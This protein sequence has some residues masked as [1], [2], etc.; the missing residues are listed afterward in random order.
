MRK[1]LLVSKLIAFAFVTGLLSIPLRAQE[2]NVLYEETFD[3]PS[4]YPDSTIKALPNGWVA[5]GETP[6][7]VQSYKIYDKMA[8]TGEF[9]IVSGYPQMS[10]R[11]DVAFSPLFEMKA[12]TDYRIRVK[13]M[14]PGLSPRTSE[15]KITVGTGQDYDS[16][17][18]YMYNDR[19]KAIDKWTLAEVIYTPSQDGQYCVGLWNCST[20][21]SAGDVYYDTFSIEEI[22]PEPE[23]VWEA[24]LPYEESFDDTTHYTADAVLPNG[25]VS[26][27]DNAFQP[28]KGDDYGYVPNSGENLL[29]ANPSY[30]AG[31]NDVTF[32]P[33]LEMEAGVTYQVSFYL[34]LI[35]LTRTPSFKFTVG[36]GQDIGAQTTILKAYENTTTSG[37][38]KVEINFTPT[39]TAQYCFAFWACSALSMDGFMLIDDFVIESDEIAE[40]GWA[41]S[42][43]YLETFDDRTHYDGV[44]YLPV[45]WRATGDEPF[46]TAAMRSKP[47]ISGAY[48]MV[49]SPSVFGERRDI[50]Y[51]PMLEMEGG[52]EYTVS[53]Y[54]Y[55]P[56]G[57]NPATFRFTAGRE[58]AYDMQDELFTVTDS[59]M[60]DWELVTLN[61]TPETTGEYCFAF[62]AN[63][64]LASDGYYCIENFSLRK[65]SDVLP[66]SGA[67]YMSNTLNSLLSGQ[68]LVF[69]NKPYKLINQVE[70]ADSYEWSVSGT[71][72]I[73][74][75]T[76]RE[77]Y[78]SFTQSGNYTIKLVTTNKGGDSEFTLNMNFDVI[79]YEGISSEAVSTANDQLDLVYQQADL[80]AYREDGTIQTRDTYDILYHYAVGVNRYYR[81]IAERFEIPD[82]QEMEVSSV[83]FNMMSYNIYMNTG[84]E[85]D[86][87]KNVK[88]VFYPEKDGKPDLENPFYEE[89]AN[90]INKL[91][92]SEIYLYKRIGWDLAEVTK[93]TG[94]FYIALEFDKLMMDLDKEWTVGSFFGADTRIHVNG[95]TTLYVKPEMAIEG[96]DYVPDGEY[97]RA[98]EFS[99]ELKGY[100]FTIMPW[101][102]ITEVSSVSEV[103]SNVRIYAS[104]DGS[105]LKVDGLNAGDRVDI[106]SISGRLTASVR[107][108]S[109]T[110]YLPIADWP[111]GVYIIATNGYSIKFVK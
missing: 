62:W 31:R 66:P 29:L 47:A 82:N 92:D 56:G 24:S 85:D 87:D 25:W 99:P 12:G 100:S 23:P 54:L 1:R 109:S 93:V 18:S 30:S 86:S 28:V 75:P 78:I 61:Y 95:E 15:M 9:F 33:M 44:S 83:S 20:L 35:A 64:E 7:S 14:M 43:P 11:Q 55:L 48:Y 8:D 3:D 67:I 84:Q 37:W 22:V 16:H 50:A 79:D 68:P 105:T 10:N 107:A 110:L 63:S 77:P 98:D 71:A 108:D 36:T 106:Y 2:I 49:A 26:N 111:R 70:G 6:F 88:L 69:P 65:S 51:T 59:I 81:A 21:S 41:P 27:S 91:G 13:Y 74:D 94:T 103:E 46:I 96:S 40:P 57:D 34:N 45:G 102:K 90:I 101:I 73:S 104:V 19:D 80:P 4:H 52:V 60:T 42:I 97:C 89:T 72:Q 38:E 53:F 32:T 58:Q 76:V 17:L 39:E 5:M